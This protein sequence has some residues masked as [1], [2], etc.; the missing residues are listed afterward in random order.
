MFWAVPT[1]GA[2]S[3]SAPISA[4][5]EMPIAPSTQKP[6]EAIIAGLWENTLDGFVRYRKRTPLRKDEKR[7]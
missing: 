4:L 5:V 6:R 1:V 3:E 2:V 7:G